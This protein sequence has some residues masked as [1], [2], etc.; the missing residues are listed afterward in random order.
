MSSEHVLAKR[1]GSLSSYEKCKKKNLQPWNV[2]EEDSNRKS[3][4]RGKKD[5]DI[6]RRWVLE[7]A[8]SAASSCE[9]V[10]NGDVMKKDGYHELMRENRNLPPLHENQGKE[11]YTL[12]LIQEI[13]CQK[14]PFAIS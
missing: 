5:I 2:R 7:R 9:Q 4:D 11:I 10:T 12:C 14:R 8:Q 1:I 3:D 6:L 13:I